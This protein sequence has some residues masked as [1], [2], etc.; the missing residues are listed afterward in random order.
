MGYDIELYK[1]PAKDILGTKGYIIKE[2]H[3]NK[4]SVRRGNHP[5]WVKEAC[6]E[7]LYGLRQSLPC[8]V[9]FRSRYVNPFI[10]K[11]FK[12]EENQIDVTLNVT[13][14][15]KFATALK[16]ALDTPVTPSGEYMSGE[17]EE[18]VSAMIR[19]LRS[20]SRHYFHFG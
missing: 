17:L 20:G 16:K 19:S 15:K 1:I 13:E 11:H 14:S 7:W 6:D 8:V 12:T 3:E 10:R 2:T 9:D 18:L 4:K 5:E